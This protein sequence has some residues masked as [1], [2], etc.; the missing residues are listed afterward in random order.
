M[1]S[2]GWA[3]P[4]PSPGGSELGMGPVELLESPGEQPCPS[5][6]NQLF[7]FDPLGRREQ[8]QWAEELFQQVGLG[9]CGVGCGGWV[10]LCPDVLSSLEMG[11][12][13]HRRGG[14]GLP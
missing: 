1:G 12:W 3:Q 9:C 7:C 4:L 14:W 8:Q 2:A 5:E 10:Q 11:G 13:L 6:P